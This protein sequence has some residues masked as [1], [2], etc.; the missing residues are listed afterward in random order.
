MDDEFGGRY[1]KVY[2]L[3]R[4][5]AAYN[6]ASNYRVTERTGDPQFLKKRNTSEQ[7]VIHTKSVTYPKRSRVGESLVQC[8]GTVLYRL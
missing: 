1:W 2:R 8:S 7:M 4:R 3:L 6:G 5:P